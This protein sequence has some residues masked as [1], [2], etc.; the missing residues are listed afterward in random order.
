MGLFHASNTQFIH[1]ANVQKK[2]ARRDSSLDSFSDDFSRK[3]NLLDRFRRL[4]YSVKVFIV[5]GI[6]MVFQV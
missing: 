4:E 6:A 2:Y 3:G 1:V 5:V